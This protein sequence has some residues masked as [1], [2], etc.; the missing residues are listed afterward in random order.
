MKP[1]RVLVLVHKHLV[2]PDAATGVDLAT[3]EWKTEFDVI[4][5][6]RDNGHEVR[7]L[8]IQDELNPIR[9]TIDEWKPTTFPERPG[10]WPERDRLRPALAGGSF[11]RTAQRSGAGGLRRYY[12]RRS[13]E[14]TRGAAA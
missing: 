5:T 7:P 14:F 1:Q 2:P 3:V 6:L 4:S 13:I 8:G 10:G 9:Q 11:A 12:A